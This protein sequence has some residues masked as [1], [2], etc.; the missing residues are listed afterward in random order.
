MNCPR[1]ATSN[2]EQASFCLRCGSKLVGVDEAQTF[3]GMSMP[4]VPGA[5]AAAPKPARVDVAAVL[6]P[7]PSSL[8]EMATA[9]PWAFGGAPMPDQV[10]FGP[11]YRIERMLGQGGMGAVYKAYDKELDRTVALK[12]VRPGLAVDPNTTQRFKQELLLASKITHRNVLRIH[13]LGDANGVKFISMAY[14]DGTDLHGLLQKEGKLTVERTVRIARQMCAALDAAHQE[15]VV[16]RDFKPQNILLDA[17]E[18]VYV[19]DFGLAKSL[20]AE[21]SMTRSG[22]F[23]GTPRYMAPEQ[24]QGGKIDARADIYALGL[25]LYEMVTGDVP[26]HADSA[27][28]LMFKR[29]HEAPASPKTINPDLPDWIERVIMKCI[30][31]DQELRYAG[32]SEVLGDLEKATAP[33]PLPAPA[34]V[35]TPP[36]PEVKVST[37][38]RKLIAAVLAA[39]LV[40]SGIVGY[41][42]LRRRATPAQETAAATNFLAVLPFEVR[43]DEKSL[44]YV[45]GGLDEALNA[46]LF[47]LKSLHTASPEAVA[48]LKKGATVA[49]IANSLGVN[50]VAQGQVQGNGDKLRIIMTLDDA[51]SGKRIWTQ[52]FSGV[53]GDLLT[54]EDEIYS[55]LIAAINLKPSSDELARTTAHPTEKADAYELYLRGRN[56]MHGQVDAKAVQQAIDLFQQAI[57]KDPN[58]ALA[59]TGIADASLRMYRNTKEASWAEKAVG[60]ALQADQFGDQLPEVH[61]A[62]GSAYTATGKTAEAIA[63]LKRAQYLSPNSDEAYRRLGD[64]YRAAGQKQDA[65]EAYKKAAEVNPYYWSN[66]NALGGAY[67]RYGD[68]DNALKAYQ[69]VA[70]LAPNNGLGYSNIGNVYYAQEKWDDAATYFQKSIEVEPSYLGY[71]NL[72]T[73]YFYR[74][75]YE[76]AAKMFEKAVELNPDQAIAVGN[77]G[78]SYRAAGQKDK[79]DAAYSRAI[80]LIQKDLQVNPKD[81]EGMGNLALYYAKKGDSSSALRYIRNARSLAPDQVSLVYVEATVD[82][83]TGRSAEALAQLKSALE[84]GYPI[85]EVKN[86][87]DLISLRPMPQYQALIDQYAAKK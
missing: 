31:K 73:V 59:Y 25:I 55:K 63:E 46:K 8:N 86:D 45:A 53:E 32:A 70:R 12:L 62:L 24:V 71:T 76:D 49:E 80:A 56:S 43:G 69:Q 6:T 40:V 84:K 34:P 14:I 17:N 79:A 68:Y 4:P 78:D 18:N 21:S 28:Q 37:S 11:R 38:R 33:P 5:A 16:H 77:L 74:Q 23:L 75:R 22:E 35:V 64:A 54:L 61:F 42:V 1:C 81:A 60:A 83:L 19:S 66:F 65:V 85:A 48:K 36:P 58:F 2:P 51:K 15:G 82:A 27:I 9:G 87:V 41:G 10:D 50:L 39:L 3:A 57:A 52:E 20:E 26:F 30:Q 67:L 13:D 44:G 47:P 72:G 7:P 29:V